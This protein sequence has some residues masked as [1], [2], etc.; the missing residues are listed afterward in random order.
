MLRRGVSQIVLRGA[1]GLAQAAE[2][3]VKLPPQHGIAGRY[4]AAL[5]MAAV[6][7]D[8][9]SKVESELGSVAQLMSESKDFSTFITDP[10]VPRNTKLDG[11]DAVLSKMGASEIT[12]NFVG[13]L[14]ANNRLVELGKIVSKFEEIAAEQRGEVKAMVTTAE[15]LSADEVEEIKRGLQPLLKPGQKLTLEEVVDPSIIGGVILALG[16]RYVDMSILARVKKLQQIVR[17]AV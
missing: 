13:L 1:R 6:K 8:S 2:K 9:L 15:G 11:L 17:D 7:S 16:D 12:K 10:S 4:A 5:Y 14:S 3:E